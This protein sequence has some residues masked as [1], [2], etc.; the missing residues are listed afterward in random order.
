MQVAR[1]K[2]RRTA[3]G[4]IWLA[5][6][7]L[8]AMLIPLAAR[9]QDSAVQAAVDANGDDEVVYIDQNG[10]VRALDQTDT[11]AHTWKES[12]YSPAG[13]WRQAA[14]G[15][16]TGEGDQEIVAIGGDGSNGRL[17]IYDPV[18]AEGDLDEN[19]QI[20]GVP[21]TTLYAASLPGTPR[22][23]GVGEFDPTVAGR[24]IIYTYDVPGS[25][26]GNRK[27][28]VVILTQTNNPPD[29]R[30]W[31]VLA[32]MMNSRSWSDMVAGNLEGTD[33]DNLV[34]IDEDVSL[35]AAYRL[36]AGSLI[37]YYTNGTGSKE[38]NSAAIGNIEATSALPELALVRTVDDPLPSLV[39][40]RYQQVNRFED[41]YLHHF[42]PSPRVVF[43]ADISGNGDDEI[44]VLRNV[45][46]T[47]ACATPYTTA[48][49]QLI[50][51]NRSSEVLLPFEV[52]LDTVNAFR[53]GAG[54]D[55]DG[56]GKDEIAVISANQL[57]IFNSPDASTADV[58]NLEV[59]SNALTIAI[60][61]LDRNGSPKPDTLQAFPDRF[62]YAVAAGAQSGK[63]S[64]QIYNST[65]GSVSIPIYVRVSPAVSWVHWS[66]SSAQTPATLTISVDAAELLPGGA[67]GAKVLVETSRTNVAN[68]PLSIPLLVVVTD[69]L[70]VRPANAVL[71]PFPCPEPG[72]QPQ[73]TLEVLGSAGMTF[74]AEVK[75]HTLEA[76]RMLLNPA[77]PLV[78]WPIDQASWIMSAQSLTTLVPATIVLGFDVAQAATFNQADVVVYGVLG[79]VPYRRVATVSL[80]CAPNMV[81]LPQINR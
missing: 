14:L 23:I 68:A 53:Y 81:Y 38:W 47:T 63:S 41:V 60:G 19:Q 49:L 37:A 43:L 4:H 17:V 29:G 2:G 11:N 35:L 6:I 64:T 22:L 26:P 27:T 21:W 51:R 32:G 69:G 13:G 1:G 18:V 65:N 42:T 56:D 54:G 71:A 28:Q 76:D 66:L 40:L 8:L 70:V 67:Y 46:R 33:V 58:T 5:L 36:S 55:V 39:V 79:N 73:L 48:P 75:P 61:N 34:L 62:D 52:C 78:N 9:A 7:G 24:E 44:F 45:T 74:T 72:L 50:M 25:E 30:A 16:F 3:V 31:R 59:A 12:W 20:N 15:D 57:R 80:V 77:A 10:V